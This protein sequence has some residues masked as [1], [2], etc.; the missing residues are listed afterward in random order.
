MFNL[1]TTLIASA[2]ALVLG[3]GSA[4]I[5]TY[6]WQYNKYERILSDERTKQAEE[7]AKVTTRAINAERQ[8]EETTQKLDEQANQAAQRTNDLLAANRKLMSERGGVRVAATSCSN[9]TSVT[10]SASSGTFTDT[11]S[12]TGA[13]CELPRAF[14][15]ILIDT[16]AA[17]DTMRDR[18]AICQSY[19]EEIE[20]QR[21]QLEKDSKQ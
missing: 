7:V 18:L 2:L 14:T 19:A 12:P 1:Q 15:Q 13:S 9:S 20:Q 11:S 3:A 8:N 17:A 21:Q 4:G 5:A 10:N 6:K 16:F